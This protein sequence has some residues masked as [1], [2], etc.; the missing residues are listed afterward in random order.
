MQSIAC[1]LH[2]SEVRCSKAAAHNGFCLAA[3]SRQ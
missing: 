1:K 3:F 2:L